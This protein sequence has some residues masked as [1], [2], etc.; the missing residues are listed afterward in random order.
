MCL[1]R[2]SWN[3]GCARLGG[4]RFDSHQVTGPATF[5]LEIDHKIFSKVILTLPLIHNG[6]LSVSGD[7]MCTKTA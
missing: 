7:S 1:I 2:W 5:F 3:I 6:Q 4:R